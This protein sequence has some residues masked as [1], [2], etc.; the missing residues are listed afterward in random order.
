MKKLL[1]KNKYN[2]NININ[3]QEPFKED[4]SNTLCETAPATNIEAAAIIPEN[5]ILNNRDKM[6]K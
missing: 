3:L 2:Q 1:I 5:F 4:K 6:Y